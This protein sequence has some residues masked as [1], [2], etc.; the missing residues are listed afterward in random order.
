[1]RHLM[2]EK[3]KPEDIKLGFCKYEVT[4]RDGENIFSARTLTEIVKFERS[5]ADVMLTFVDKLQAKWYRRA[6]NMLRKGRKW[7]GW[8]K[9][10]KQ[11]TKGRKGTGKDSVALVWKGTASNTA[12]RWL[13]KGPCAG[14][15]SRRRRLPTVG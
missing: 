14:R 9:V 2:V 7:N 1:M 8:K 13:G 6:A 5:H 15:H 11:R 12:K 4:D 3:M 10:K